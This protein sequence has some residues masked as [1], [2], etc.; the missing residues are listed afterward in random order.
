VHNNQ[1]Q[2]TTT[3]TTTTTATTATTTTT[4]EATKFM[5]D[6]FS[7]KADVS[8][9]YTKKSQILSDSFIV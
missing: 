2:R 5:H 3:T 7:E 1:W 9:F 8:V 6:Y 4:L